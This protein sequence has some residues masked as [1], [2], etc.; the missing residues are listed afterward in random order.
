M[1]DVEEMENLDVATATDDA[2]D[3]G[4][5]DKKNKKNK[6]KDKENE[7]KEGV[8]S[9]LLTL[10]IVLFIVLIWLAIFA[11]L[12]KYDV[13]GFG[14]TVLRP[15][16]KDVPVVSEILPEVSDDQIAEEN[17]YP[18]KNLQEAM[19]RI[20]ELERVLATEKGSNK[21]NANYLAQ[22]KAEVERLKTFEENQLQFQ[23]EKDKFD[24]EIVFG[25]KAPSTEEYK[26]YYELIDP[27][28][29][30]EIYRQIVEQN[31]LEKRY[32]EQAE[33]YKSMK[34][35]EAATI[36]N[37]MSGDLELVAKILLHMKTKEAGAILAKMDSNMAAKIT[38]K[39]S[40][41]QSEG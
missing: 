4:K 31:T 12:I 36:L 11:L 38:K 40:L 26:K 9:K 13:G 8:F 33:M 1:A 34:P 30:A 27:E 17:G 24:K 15:L 28:N 23:A 20:N 10:F 29:A 16:L 37:G 19:E 7:E 5:K 2:P 3:T 18:Y 39:I 22:L 21:G 6:K 14:S 35:E 32:I 25:S 41:M